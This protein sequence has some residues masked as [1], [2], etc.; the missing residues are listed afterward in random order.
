MPT[1]FLKYDAPN[2]DQGH[3]MAIKLEGCKLATFVFHF[4]SSVDILA[5]E[6][7]ESLVHDQM[8]FWFCA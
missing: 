5:M 4:N 6:L 7:N 1:T 8:S 2:A 3:L